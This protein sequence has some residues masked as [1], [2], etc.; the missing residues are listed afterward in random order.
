[1][2][3]IVLYTVIIV[4]MLSA[5]CVINGHRGAIFS[6]KGESELYSYI[7]NEKFTGKIWTSTYGYF[8]MSV[9]V[10]ISSEENLT[11]NLYNLKVVY[12]GQEIGYFCRFNRNK[13]EYT[14]VFT[15][16]QQNEIYYSCKPSINLID[17][18]E[19]KVV[20]DNYIYDGGKYF[21]IDTLLFIVK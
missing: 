18:E 20:A 8:S 6:V 4:C 21:S 19:I 5:S 2:T 15:K 12:K 10:E 13:P 1:M 11:I 7:N 17:G 3:R 14:S 9:N 16:N